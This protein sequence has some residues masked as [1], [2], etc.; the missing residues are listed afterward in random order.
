MGKDRLYLLQT[1]YILM[2]M[3]TIKNFKIQ[4]VSRDRSFTA[5]KSKE[6]FWHNGTL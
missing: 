4:K 5:T 1:S 2:H 3:Q 6:T